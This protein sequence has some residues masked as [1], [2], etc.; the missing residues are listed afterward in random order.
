ME[1]SIGALNENDVIPEGITLDEFIEMICRKRVPAY[2]APVVSLEETAEPINGTVYELGA[3][4]NFSG[5]SNFTKNDGGVY[6]QTVSSTTIPFLLPVRPILC[7]SQ[8]MTLLSMSLL[9][10]STQR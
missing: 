9:R 4:A 7:M 5:V 8:T 2:V 1:P 10:H 3:V 6:P